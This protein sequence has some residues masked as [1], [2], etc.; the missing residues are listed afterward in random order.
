MKASYIVNFNE[1][2]EQFPTSIKNLPAFYQQ[3]N[4]DSVFLLRKVKNQYLFSY[5]K[6]L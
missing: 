2:N 1:I 5:C 4:F 3:L 6:L